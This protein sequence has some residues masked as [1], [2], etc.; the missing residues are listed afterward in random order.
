MKKIILST[1]AVST[2][3]LAGGDIAPVTQDNTSSWMDKFE[4]SVPVFAKTSK[5]KFSG[6]HYLGFVSKKE[7]GASATNNFEMR[8]NYL[9]VKAYLF[10]D[11]K[12]YLRVT[13][14]ETSGNG[15]N[16]IRIKYAYLYLDNIL[17][18]TGVEDIKTIINASNGKIEKI[19]KKLK[20]AAK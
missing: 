5:I 17:A 14:D 13:L 8:R 11:P 4:K 2:M 12:S 19:V 16:D 20:L 3:V 9:Q 6:Q 18:N 15:S 7:N 1:V 10:D